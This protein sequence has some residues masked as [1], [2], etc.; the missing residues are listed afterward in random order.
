M[1]IIFILSPV[2]SKNKRHKKNSFLFYNLENSHVRSNKNS[3]LKFSQ[4]FRYIVS[5][6]S[7]NV[8]SS[9]SLNEK[10]Q[11]N[12]ADACSAIQVKDRADCH[13][14]QSPT[15]SVCLSR[16]C[17]WVPNPSFQSQ[18]YINTPECF[19]PKGYSSYS[20]QNVTRT[21]SGFSFNGIR[22]KPSFRPN[23]I[24]LL[25]GHISIFDG[26]IIR[27]RVYNI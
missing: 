20:W 27:L 17:C 1:L 14:D 26:G 5:K 15:E 4:K 12:S 11:S 13:P 22:E 7:Y 16:G 25:E 19:Y 10:S 23:D 6:Y 8:I 3:D 9:N 18:K 24:M 21:K 2:D